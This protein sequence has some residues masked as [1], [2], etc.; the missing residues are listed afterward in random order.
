L[1]PWHVWNSG[2][3]AL[4]APS[5]LLVVSSIWLCQLRKLCAIHCLGL[6]CSPL[7]VAHSL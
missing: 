1:L 2:A 4:T 7:T 5:L 6:L 3:G